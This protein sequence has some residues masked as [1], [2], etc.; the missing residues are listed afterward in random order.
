MSTVKQEKVREHYDTIADVYDSHYDGIRGREY[1]A[2]ISGHVLDALPKGSRLLDIGCGT[3]L[4]VRQYLKTGGSAFGL[5]ISRGMIEKARQ[6][7]PECEFLVGTADKLPFS[8][9]NFDAVSSIL[10]FTY[11]KRPEDMLSET[12][13]VLRPGG[14]IAICTL[15][16]K[17]LTRGIPA[18]YHI[19]EKFRVKH[20]V[21]KNFGEHYY[22][23]REMKILFSNAGF[24]DIRV[25]WCSFA[26][27]SIPD[28]L[29]RLAR[30]VEP[31]I[32]RRIPQLAYNI[33]VSARKPE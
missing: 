2:H 14:K 29:F 25:E 31:F 24:E 17:L 10:A 23:E 22:N 27:I 11:L 33:S 32:E 19:G 16:K 4:F 8:D 3:G 5:D 15:G 12:Y 6:R 9:G 20:L 18:I 13:R 7:C 30:R 21:M 1:H 28:P 26:H